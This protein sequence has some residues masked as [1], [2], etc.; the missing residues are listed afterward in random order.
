MLPIFFLLVWVEQFS[1]ICRET[2]QSIMSLQDHAQKCLYYYNSIQNCF[3]VAF[4]CIFCGSQLFIFVNFFNV[5]SFQF[6][7]KF[8]T[9]ERIVFSVSFVLISL[10]LIFIVLSLTFTI[11]EALNSLKSLLIPI[12]KRLGKKGPGLPL[13]LSIYFSSLG[14]SQWAT[15][16]AEP[17]GGN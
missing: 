14:R 6:M 9:W 10:H 12:R 4:L 11:E 16:D 8:D 15:R 5:I 1:R 3:G 7:D 2:E 13:L 17:C